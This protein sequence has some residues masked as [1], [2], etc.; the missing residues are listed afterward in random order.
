[1]LDLLHTNKCF[2]LTEANKYIFKESANTYAP[3]NIYES[4]DSE[5][6]GIAKKTKILRHSYSNMTTQKCCIFLKTDHTKLP[7]SSSFHSTITTIQWKIPFYSCQYVSMKPFFTKLCENTAETVHCM[8]SVSSH[9]CF[10]LLQQNLT[11]K[12]HKLIKKSVILMYHMVMS[13]SNVE[14]GRPLDYK[15]FRLA[16]FWLVLCKRSPENLWL[17]NHILCSN[18]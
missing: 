8:N 4:Y 18:Q 15:F 17:L 1:M 3:W 2:S 11:G 13:A 12:V 9:T 7:F 5:Q 16:K 10:V 14:D 6:Q